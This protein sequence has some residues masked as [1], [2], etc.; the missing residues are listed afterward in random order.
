LSDDFTSSKN[1]PIQANRQFLFVL[2]GAS[3][4]A[5][6]YSALADCL[7]RCLAPEPVEIL[8]A[9]GPGRGYC[10]EGGIFNIRY[11]A[12]GASGILDSISA[13]T[14]PPRRIIALI[15][16]IGNDIMYGVPVSEIT[17]CLSALLKQFSALDAD[18]FL[19]PIPIDLSEDVSK[20]QFRILRSIFYPNSAI[21]YEKAKEAVFAVNDFLRANAGERVHLL[22]S[23]KES[24]GID[25]IHY[26][27]FQSHK[28]WSGV[29]HEMF[30][31]LN[32]PEVPKISWGSAC[33]SILANIG[34]LVF[35]DMFSVRKKT[36]QTY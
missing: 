15:T 22:P 33:N 8:H 21:D 36:P 1:T 28:A 10:A 34:R 31:V 25:K 19:Q 7:V 6:G 24:M 23:G 29:T 14:A 12:I 13:Q 18:V 3:N 5:R 30:R 26:S 27:V 35:C 11:P 32:V 4:L 20:N 9:M 16:D 17:A 2:M